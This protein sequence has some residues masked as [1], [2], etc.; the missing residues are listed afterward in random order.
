MRDLSECVLALVHV[1]HEGLEQRK[2][3]F[4]WFRSHA[5]LATKQDLKE[6]EKR[7]TEAITKSAGITPS[8]EAAAMRVQAALDRLDSTI[9]DK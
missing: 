9:P 7:L 5:G 2:T 4:D 8:I 6:M 1:L 3:E